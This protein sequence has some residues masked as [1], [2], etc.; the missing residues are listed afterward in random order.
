M[1][2]KNHKFDV[3]I[4]KVLKLMINSLYSN[5]DVAIRELVSNA[6]DACDK[7]RYL[8]LQDNKILKEEETL[9]IEIF[10]DKK[11]KQ[12]S[13]K[14]NGIGMS[15][16]DLINNLGTIA[17]SGTEEFINSLT[18]D[19]KKNA[20]L[21][22]QFGVGFYA[23]FMV[24]DNVEVI[25]R[26]YDGEKTLKWSSTGDGRFDIDDSSEKL[27]KGTKI[28]LNL[29]EEDKD[30]FLDKFFIKNIVSKY[31]DH[32][33]VSI[34]LSSD[35]DKEEDK[36]EVINSSSAIWTKQ[37]SEVTKEQ[38]EDFYKNISHLPGEPFMTIHSHSEGVLEFSNLLFIPT[39]KPFDLYNQE[40]RAT[41]VKLYVKKIFIS[42]DIELIPAWLRFV[43][44]VVD[45]QDL[46]L[47]ISRETLQH[48]IIIE[49]I[50]KS[51][52]NKI[53]SELKKKS[54]KEDEYLKFWEN[55][56]PV[57]KEGLCEY[58]E[59]KEKILDISRFYTSKSL[60]N[61]ITLQKYFDNRSK[62]QDKIYYIT[63]ESIDSIKNNPKLEG[64]NKNDIEV[65]FLVDPVD[66]F[67]VTS[68]NEYQKKEFQSIN[69][70]D[71]DLD[72][73]SGKD[74]DKKDE[75]KSK[76]IEKGF[77]GLITYIKSVLGDKIKDVKIS[78]K[79]NSSPV[80]LAV[81]GIG[82][83][84]R[85]E[86]FLKSQNQLKSTSAKLFE[87]NPDHKIIK[88]LQDNVSDKNLENQNKNIVLSLYDQACIIEGEP[89]ANPK[90]FS[91]RINGLIEKTF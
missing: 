4:D 65:L 30:N 36:P 45:S 5:K 58:G 26:K 55:F 18:E 11:N 16:D 71:I 50:K 88:H 37:K 6:A 69:R 44:G 49:K 61:P 89:I 76:E 24:S 29:K 41:G 83:D 40:R 9:K 27:E 32:I 90:E 25:S 38:Y 74:K 46:P 57:L 42:E 82:M 35:E 39:M 22:G 43:K 68:T 52:V 54:K 51:I 10:L 87:I 28:I 8:S 67:W 63:G 15:E 80:C 13:I 56:G 21:I 19:K 75:E 20:E 81:D 91:D 47:N 23:S 34:E 62:D 17:K 86:R 78:K 48:N 31:S 12:I 60:D 14:D 2:V 7:L 1:T 59:F 53:L 33:S 85:M 3:K 66:D 73:I 77:E 84:I 64:F 72:K 79:L 70:S